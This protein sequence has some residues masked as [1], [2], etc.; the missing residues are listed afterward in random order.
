M[1]ILF[2][3]ISCPHTYLEYRKIGTAV[4]TFLTREKTNE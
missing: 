4:I 3:E 2:F 1:K